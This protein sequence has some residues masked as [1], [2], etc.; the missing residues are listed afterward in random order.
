MQNSA[1]EKLNWFE[2]FYKNYLLYTNAH[3]KL[4]EFFHFVLQEHKTHFFFFGFFFLQCA[5]Y[6]LQTHKYQLILLSS[7][8]YFLLNL[9]RLQQQFRI[10]IIISQEF[11]FLDF[12]YTSNCTS[13]NFGNSVHDYVYIKHY[14]HICTY[15][16]PF[17]WNMWKRSESHIKLSS[18]F[19]VYMQAMETCSAT[20]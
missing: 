14:L 9:S 20:S 15:K 3:Y 18:F 11:F 6:S 16:G 7:N 12:V 2:K 4:S 13:K 19:A 17:Y 1:N 8:K 5:N 10:W